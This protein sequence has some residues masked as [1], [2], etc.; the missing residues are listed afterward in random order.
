MIMA[1]VILLTITGC[2][3]VAT[4]VKDHKLKAASNQQEKNDDKENNSKI[5]QA[6]YKNTPVPTASLQAADNTPTL[7][8]VPTNTPK[9]T[10]TPTDTPVPK[11]VIALDPGKG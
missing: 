9:P 5:T 4:A 1:V 2:L 6:P 7:T 3:G 10:A 11:L 8:P